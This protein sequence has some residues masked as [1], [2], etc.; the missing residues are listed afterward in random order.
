MTEII[1]VE[2]DTVETGHSNVA[3]LS[4]LITSSSMCNKLSGNA[5]VSK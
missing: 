3:I 2:R 1:L 5:D 4:T